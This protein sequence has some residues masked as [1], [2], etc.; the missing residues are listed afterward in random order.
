MIINRAFSCYVKRNTFVYLFLGKGHDRLGE[1]R[2]SPRA[3]LQMRKT[4]CSLSSRACQHFFKVQLLAPRPPSPHLS[5]R[6]RPISTAAGT[7][8]VEIYRR[9]WK[10]VRL[11]RI[12]G[13]KTTSKRG[14]WKSARWESTRP[15]PSRRCWDASRATRNSHRFWC[16]IDV[17]R[18]Q[19]PCKAFL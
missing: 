16:V 6:R 9:G 13:V 1:S 7:L 10:R 12:L 2:K 19:P 18:V 5:T 8:P 17:L 15:G 3:K 11:A 4:T 14:P